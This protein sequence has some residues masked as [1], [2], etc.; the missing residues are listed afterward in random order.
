[1]NGTGSSGGSEIFGFSFPSKR[2][3]RIFEVERGGGVVGGSDGG[4][5]RRVGA[6]GGGEGVFEELRIGGRAIATVGK[7]GWWRGRVDGGDA[8]VRGRDA[9]AHSS[10]SR[11]DLLLVLELLSCNSQRPKQRLCGG[12]QSVETLFEVGEE[13]GKRS[14]HRPWTFE[15]GSSLLRWRGDRRNSISC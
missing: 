14:R 3:A 9:D 7:E 4:R 11:V 8:V 5:G 13:R 2:V 1:M 15:D 12:R 10:S 6:G